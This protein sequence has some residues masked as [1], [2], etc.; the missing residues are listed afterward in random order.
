MVVGL[1]APAAA[2][3]IT[4][5]DVRG[6][7]PLF[8]KR[9]ATAHTETV[10]PESLWSAAVW[11]QRYE[12]ALQEEQARI[13]AQWPHAEVSSEQRWV[14][15]TDDYAV[16][17]VVDFE[18]TR[19]EISFDAVGT[20]DFRQSHGQL[21]TELESL[22]STRIGAAWHADPINQALSDGV[23]GAGET[24]AEAESLVMAA[25][26]T[27]TQPSA[28]VIRR[29]AL[30]LANSAR[31]RYHDLNA[32]LQLVTAPANRRLTYTM[33][34]P[35][36][37]AERQARRYQD[38]VNT[39]GREYSVK[40][41]LIYAIIHTES[42]FNPLARSHIPAYG[43]MQI[44]PD[45]AGRDV[46]EKVFKK[47]QR[48]SANFLFNPRRNIEIGSAY[49]NLL[50]STYLKQIRQ[51]ESRLYYTIAAY[52]GG[53]G[54]VARAFSNRGGL[55]QAIEIINTLP[56]HEVRRRLLANAP[57]KETRDYLRHVLTRRSLYA[58]L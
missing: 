33:D 55:K 45:T 54:A 22:L 16:K 20:G 8:K 3:W 9:T 5:Q 25:L 36:D 28:Q 10:Q 12:Q 41:D 35:K 27:R 51:P 18:Q 42:Y 14:V 50:Y 40:P 49:L 11:A 38:Y 7:S 46:M 31:L 52:N 21:V 57:A 34:L 56:P 53:L 32:G 24:P 2:G 6:E 1:Q 44:V 17:R 19:I 58:H 29:E 48:L 15:Y 4:D 26:F 43:L 39:S 23:G 30:R 13:N 37:W 47:S